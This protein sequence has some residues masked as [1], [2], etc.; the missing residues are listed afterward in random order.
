MHILSLSLSLSPRPP[1]LTIKFCSAHDFTNET[2]VMKNT[3]LLYRLGIGC[4]WSSLKRSI[5]V[6]IIEVTT[7]K[8]QQQQQQQRAFGFWVGKEQFVK[9]GKKL[10]C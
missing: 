7:N 4:C 9:R 8:Q 2:N 10:Q 1:F 5:I 6:E 3:Y